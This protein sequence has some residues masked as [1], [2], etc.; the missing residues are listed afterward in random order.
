MFRIIRHRWFLLGQYFFGAIAEIAAFIVG[1]LV[2]AARQGYLN[3]DESRRRGYDRAD[4]AKTERYRDIINAAIKKSI[5]N[6][7]KP[8]GKREF[9]NHCGDDCSCSD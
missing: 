4:L 6:K 1:Y 2:R 7:A 9:T 3:G 8:F 5:E